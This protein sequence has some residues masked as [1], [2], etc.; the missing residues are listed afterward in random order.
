MIYIDFVFK[1]FF[2]IICFMIIVVKLILKTDLNYS[3]SCLIIVLCN[4]KFT[5]VLINL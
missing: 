1:T 4:I 2:S 5:A 3:E